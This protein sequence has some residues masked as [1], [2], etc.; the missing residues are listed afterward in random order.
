[1]T[2]NGKPL[3]EKIRDAFRPEWMGSEPEI[4]ELVDTLEGRVW[5]YE[6]GSIVVEGFD[7]FDKK[8]KSTAYAVATLCA[9]II[10]VRPTPWFSR[11]EYERRF[12]EE[13]QPSAIL[14][15]ERVA[16]DGERWRLPPHQTALRDALDLLEENF[17]ESE[18]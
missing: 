14:E 3:P 7:G 15:R 1:M 8:Q 16:P 12:G 18:K 6:E 5:V 4:A 2:D 9:N 17:L 10:G 13:I 11:E